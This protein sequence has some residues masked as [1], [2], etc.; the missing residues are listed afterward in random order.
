[1]LRNYGVAIS[2][3]VDLS[4]R[5]APIVHPRVHTSTERHV[6][7]V[8]LVDNKR[9]S[10]RSDAGSVVPS[11]RGL[12][13]DFETASQEASAG[14]NSRRPSFRSPDEDIDSF[15]G[16]KDALR[17]PRWLVGPRLLAPSAQLNLRCEIKT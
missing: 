3:P 10:R 16:T 6:G 9:V 5:P 14:T 12:Q 1:M 17:C 2:D 13:P 11:D 7:L 15:C 4:E 8:P